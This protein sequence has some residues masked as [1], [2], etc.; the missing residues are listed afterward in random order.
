MY[1]F[2]STIKASLRLLRAEDLWSCSGR[3]L[4]H[5]AQF[6]STLVPENFSFQD[7]FDVYWQFSISYSRFDTE[8][9][10]KT[11]VLFPTLGS[12]HIA[13]RFCKKQELAQLLSLRSITGHSW[14][15]LL[16]TWCGT[17]WQ[18]SKAV[19]VFPCSIYTVDVFPTSKILCVGFASS[20]FRCPHL[21]LLPPGLF[22][23]SGEKKKKK[24]VVLE[25]YILDMYFRK[26]SVMPLKKPLSFHWLYRGLRSPAQIQT[27]RTQS[28]GAS[29]SVCLYTSQFWLSE[30]KKMVCRFSMQVIQMAT[31]WQLFHFP[32]L[33]VVLLFN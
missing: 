6:K 12:Q 4:H 13:C 11:R 29:H 20:N 33:L 24:S 15:S 30:N 17:S 8:T 22:I 19:S 23:S 32:A 2:E 10:H 3:F 18:V 7:Y 5:S 16:K 31:L 9:N 14:G 1:I 26:K 27:L 25:N 28:S 21:N